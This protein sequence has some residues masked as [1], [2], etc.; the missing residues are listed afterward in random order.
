RVTMRVLVLLGLCL[1][2]HTCGSFPNRDE[3]V[4]V[5]LDQ[6]PV[7]GSDGTTYLNRCQF[8]EAAF[9][10]PDLRTRGKGPC[11]TGKDPDPGHSVRVSDRDR[12]SQS[13]SGLDFSPGSG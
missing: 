9:S 2:L 13:G 8:R 3:Q 10:D 6:D 1:S 7:C 12:V 5:C 11:K 4:C